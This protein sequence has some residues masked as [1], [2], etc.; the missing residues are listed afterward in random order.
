MLMILEEPYGSLVRNTLLSAATHWQSVI[1]CWM[2]M[3]EKIKHF[4]T[5]SDTITFYF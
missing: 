5:H 1:I 4:F 3:V 2:K